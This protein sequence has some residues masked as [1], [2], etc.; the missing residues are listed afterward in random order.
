MYQ[1]ADQFKPVFRALGVPYVAVAGSS[2]SMGG[3][4]SHE[5]QFPAEIGQ[6]RLL[7]CPEC[8]RGSNIEVSDQR[9][10]SGELLIFFFVCFRPVFT[11]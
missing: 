8:E 6:D 3:S 2:G 10:F 7:I 4:V 11:F 9:H 1:S 5:F